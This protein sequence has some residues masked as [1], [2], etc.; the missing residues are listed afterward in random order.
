MKCQLENITVHYVRRGS[1]RPMV[2]LHGFTLDHRVMLGCMEPVFAERKGWQRIYL[3]LPGMGKTPARP[4]VTSSDQML[5]V[6]QQFIDA[7]IPKQHFV[8][9]AESYG[10]YLARGLVHRRPDVIDGLLL[11]C[12]LV[13]ADRSRRILPKPTTLVKNA[14]LVKSLS[15]TEAREFQSVAVVQTRR[16]SKRFAREILAGIQLAGEPFLTNLQA[17]GY[18]LSF[19]VDDLPTPFEKPTLILTGRQDSSVGYADAWTLLDRYPRATLAVLDRAGHDLQIEQDILFNALV[20]EWLTRVEE[21][22]HA[23]GKGG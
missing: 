11:I 9:A 6:V 4:W 15:P 19:D 13:V 10:A 20:S 7:T 14:E 23:K 1:G 3:D 8:V 5:D 12:P 22:L 17:R 16:H 2:M 21:A 18:A